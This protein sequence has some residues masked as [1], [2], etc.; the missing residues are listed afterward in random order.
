MKRLVRL[1]AY[2]SQ[3]DAVS[4]L[5]KRNIVGFLQKTPEK[6]GRSQEFGSS[7]KGLDSRQMLK[8]LFL[9]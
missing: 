6:D 2:C 9:L 1:L 7:L 4:F 5:E 3:S 8:A